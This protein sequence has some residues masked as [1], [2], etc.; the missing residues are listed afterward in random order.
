MDDLI[1]ISFFLAVIENNKEVNNMLCSSSR[2]L[3]IYEKR[4][5]VIGLC[6]DAFLEKR[7]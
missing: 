6:H 3:L 5:I 7:K 2:A 4:I 1:P